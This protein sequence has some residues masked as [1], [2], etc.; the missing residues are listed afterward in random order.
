M[1]CNHNRKRCMEYD[2]NFLCRCHCQ[3]QCQYYPLPINSE[4]GGNGN[5]NGTWPCGNALNG[6]SQY[7]YINGFVPNGSTQSTQN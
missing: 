1:F 3:C 7:E 4:N 5:N 6:N 2:Q